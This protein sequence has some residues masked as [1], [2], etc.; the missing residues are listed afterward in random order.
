MQRAHGQFHVLLVD[1]H[2][3]LD[4]RGG[5]HLDVDALFRQRAEHLA[6]D[7]DVRAHAHAH[8]RHL[9]HLGVARHAAGADV[10]LHA[11]VQDGQRALVL[12]ARHG[13]GEVGLAVDGLVLDDH[14]D[15]D[16]GVGDRAQ[17]LV[18]DAGL[19]G[20]AQDGDLGFVAGKGDAGDDSGFH[21]GVFF[22]K[23]DQR[24][25]VH[26]LLERHKRVGQRRQHAGLDAVLAGELHRADLQHL[27]AEAGHFQHF[28]EGDLVQAAGV[29]DHARV[30]GVDAVDV[31]VDQALVGLDRGGNGHGRGVRA[32]AAQR[33]D[34]AVVVD[35]LEAGDHHHA[36]GI[37]VGQDA[38]VVDRFDAGLGVGRI[39]LHRNLPAGV[40][41]GVDVLAVQG[42]RQQRH[43]GL[44]AGG[45]EHVQFT[46]IGLGRNFLGESQQA[47]GLARHGRRHHDYAV[48]GA[49]PLGHALGDILDAFR[50]TH[51]SAAVFVND[52]SHLL[53]DASD[54]AKPLKIHEAARSGKAHGD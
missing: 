3:D 41:D 22:L 54:C 2:R 40:A 47:I 17:D 9:R 53:V 21:G 52:E 39:G 5:D 13:E 10:R 35:A 19:V 28:L 37:E 31:G 46:R 15:V 50:G 38:L 44:F 12:A 42:D 27:G 25:R 30:G 43:A 18:G 24:A 14:V 6:G 7:A 26:F 29:L 49:V 32:A 8:H 45:G 16:I 4:F 20:H 48:T 36:A 1:Q 11:I 51:R 33:G 23:S 34:V